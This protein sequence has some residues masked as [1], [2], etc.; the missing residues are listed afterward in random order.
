MVVPN[1]WENKKLNQLMSIKTGSRNTEDRIYGARYPFFVRS[2]Q[3]EQIDEYA[4]DCE[5]VLTAGDGVGTGKVFHYVNGKFN[6]HQR[7]YVMTEFNGIIGKYFYYFFSN[8]FFNEVAKYTAKSSVD[9]VRRAM[10][11]DME[12]PL[13]SLPEQQAIAEVLSDTDSYISS[14]EKLI[15]KKLAVKQGAMQELLT[16]K[17]RLPGFSGE[18]EYVEFGTQ[19]DIL[20]GGSPRPI[21]AYL[22]TKSDGTNWIKIGDVTPNAKYICSTEERIIPEGVAFSRSVKEGDFILSN[23]MSFG[24]PYILNINGCIHD[25]WLTIQN[26]QANF[27]IDF[28]YYLLGSEETIQ[29]YINMAAGSSVQNLNKDKV[30]KLIV[31]KPSKSEQ[32]AIAEILTDM[33][34]EIDALTAK[35]NKSKLIKQGMMQKLLTGEIRL[36]KEE[37]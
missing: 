12:I 1:G 2:Q 19:A 24:R 11:A 5:A 15:E 28:L 36:I 20:R 8:I 27:D 10:I 9:S 17:R 18:W 30:Q 7:V 26:Y 35:L 14:L 37:N 25:G 23:S 34:E 4:Y 6:A 16:G 32:S 33:D 13:P 21:Q 31:H 3:V 29:Q 22:T